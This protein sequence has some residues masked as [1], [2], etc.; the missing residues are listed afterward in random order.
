[1]GGKQKFKCNTKINQSYNNINIDST[2]KSKGL[3]SLIQLQQSLAA[4]GSNRV[5]LHILYLIGFRSYFHFL[6]ELTQLRGAS[7]IPEGA[8]PPG[9]SWLRACIP[10]AYFTSQLYAHLFSPRSSICS[11]VN[12][13]F[14]YSRA[15]P[16]ALQSTH[17]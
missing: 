8:P 16:P 3:L 7:M 9:P 17:K 13:V 14:F 2:S 4:Q 12:V 15:E 11:Y 6:Q 5:Q 10:R 1:M